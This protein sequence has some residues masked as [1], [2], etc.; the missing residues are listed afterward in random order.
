MVF[1][2]LPQLSKAFHEFYNFLYSFTKKGGAF[3][4]TNLDLSR[5]IIL[6]STAHACQ[7]RK[8]TTT[9]YIVHPFETAM[10]LQ[11]ENCSNDVIVAGLLHDILEDTVITFDTLKNEFGE[12]IAD[13]VVTCT[14]DKTL[15]WE[16][17]KNNKVKFLTE[18]N[19]ENI[20]KI[21]CADKLSNMRSITI[22]LEKYQ[23][24]L[25]KRFNRGKESQKWYYG[26]V[27]E[28]LFSLKDLNMYQE[29]SYLYE[30][31]FL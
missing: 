27:I 15:S 12:K 19:D 11:K 8:G 18:T 7:L 3:L 23:D 29:L 5:G 16:E 6:A 14:E 20:K 13:M 22:D 25:W 4:E 30:K 1:V 28:A 24:D 2:K 10:I 9:P 17:R 31:A 21:A 26:R